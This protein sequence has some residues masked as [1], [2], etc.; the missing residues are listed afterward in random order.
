MTLPGYPHGHPGAYYPPYPPAQPRN[1][2]GTAAMIVGICGAVIGLV[3]FLFFLSGPLALVALGLGIA[4]LVLVRRGRATNKGMALTGTILGGVALL[5]AVGGLLFILFMID[6]GDE[7]NGDLYEDRPPAAGPA[8]PSPSVSAAPKPMKFGETYTYEDGV[9]VTVDKPE[10]YEP[11]QVAVGHKDGN[12][13]LQLKV[14]IV[15]NGKDTFDLRAHVPYVRDAEG[16]R[17]PEIFDGHGAT[18]VFSG[19]LLPGKQATTG[20][21]YSVPPGAAKELQVETGASND[22]ADVMWIGP[23]R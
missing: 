13:A 9:T 12:L 6:K 14:T 19:K 16:A 18:R 7:E 11:D 4:G 20:F 17:A 1:G 21:T 23:G 15:N 10:P 5:M 22:R 3:P 2:M 8:E